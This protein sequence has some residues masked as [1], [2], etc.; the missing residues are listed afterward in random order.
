MLH[1]KSHLLCTNVTCLIYYFLSFSFNITIKKFFK[2]LPILFIIQLIFFC[3]YNIFY[4]ID[5]PFKNYLFFHIYKCEYPLI[6]ILL[7]LYTFNYPQPKTIN[8]WK[9]FPSFSFLLFKRGQVEYK[10]MIFFFP[11]FLYNKKI[12][13][14]YNA[15]TI[16]I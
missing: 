2:Q 15:T 9:I 11:L 5:F 4:F 1:L 16:T 14:L 10:K 13:L 12:K 3:T 7:C 8:R 6:F